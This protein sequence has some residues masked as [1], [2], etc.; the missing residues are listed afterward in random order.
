MADEKEKEINTVDE[1]R[2]RRMNRQKEKLYKT[3]LRPSKK[4][5]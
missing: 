3:A 1:E 5:P 2:K 4:K